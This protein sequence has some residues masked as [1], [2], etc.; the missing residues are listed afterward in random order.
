MTLIEQEET[1][2]TSPDGPAHNLSP[3][4]VLVRLLQMV[5]QLLIAVIA[6]GFAGGSSPAFATLPLFV[7]GALLLTGGYYYISWR[8]FFYRLTADEI[9]IES[10]ILSRNARSIPYDRI[11]DV[12][13]EQKLLLR[14]LGL[15]SV[16]MET[17]SGGGDDGVLNYVA[18]DEAERL[19]TQIRHRKLR[20][21][22]NQS[23]AP[24]ESLEETTRPVFA[25]NLKRVLLAGFFNFSLV[26]FAVLGAA[27]QNLDF[28]I[29]DQYFDPR[30]WLAVATGQQWISDYS[31]LAQ[32]TGLIALVIGLILLGITTGVIR[33]LFREYGF[34][35]DRTDSGFR[36]RRGL[37]TLS[38][39]AI[40]LRRIQSA[41]IATGPVRKSFGWYSLK[42]QSLAQD[43][44]NES[45]HMAAPLAHKHEIDKILVEPE[46]PWALSAPDLE[47]VARAGWVLP[48]IA[49]LLIA[50]IFSIAASL[51]IDGRFIW[52][53][54]VLPML[55]IGF[56]KSWFYHRFALHQGQ[57]YVH[58]GFWR[59]RLVILPLAKIQSVDVCV[60]PILRLFG[61]AKMVLGVAGGSG[62]AP[63]SIYGLQ[64]HQALD[65]RARLLR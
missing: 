55:L 60:G 6:I 50:I 17:G 53:L 36:R 63:L 1:T 3:L 44:K 7:G 59:Q 51:T 35:L 30:R 18:R 8:R 13:I 64:Y 34:R 45:N 38:D 24:D 21:A 26:I 49:A 11:Q 2:T 40:P 47:Y 32:I 10:G 54:V 62:I 61:H 33:T 22:D 46:I 65:M 43:G 15:A 58:K 9:R 4:S 31:R 19:R 16:K 20:P 57:L 5:P 37:T 41:I 23:D 14:I 25:M 48:A 42:F 52:A 29:P 27:L 39:V 56:Y 12:N 28:L